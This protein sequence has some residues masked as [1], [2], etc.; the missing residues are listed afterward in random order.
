MTTLD[1]VYRKFGEVYEAVQ[2]LET[3]LGNVLLTHKCDD[4]GLLENPDP[5]KATSI[6][7]Q[8]NRQSLGRLA[9]GFLAENKCNENFEQILNDALVSRN[10]LTHSFYLRHNFRRNSDEGRAVMLQD[11]E[12]IHEIVLAAYKSVLPLTGID[13]DKLMEESANHALPTKHLPIP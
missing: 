2:L 10:R 8:I 11:L 6:Y 12:E 7:Q 13:L 4:A 3:Q 9:K 1:E 5:I